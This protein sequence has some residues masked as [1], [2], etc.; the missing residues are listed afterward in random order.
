MAAL[1][2]Q[3][4]P[5]SDTPMEAAAPP[6]LPWWMQTPSVQ[7]LLEEYD[8]KTD[9]E[10]AEIKRR[11]EEAEEEAFQRIA[12]RTT[13]NTPTEE[14]TQL[15][16][17]AAARYVSRLQSVHDHVPKREELELFA[18]LI[19]KLG[20]RIDYDRYEVVRRKVLE[21]GGTPGFWDEAQN[22]TRFFSVRPRAADGTVAVAALR[23]ATFDEAESLCVLASR[24]RKL[25]EGGV[26]SS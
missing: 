17:L 4:Q 16:T 5:T 9:E 26:S 15:R 18:D 13:P 20:L 19:G 6:E 1:E 14:G 3:Q 8:S 12:A 11:A 2:A 21:A 25:P 24:A 7:R 10:R 22:A 23:Q